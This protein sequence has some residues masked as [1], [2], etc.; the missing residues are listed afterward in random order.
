M[1]L[2]TDQLLELHYGLLGIGS[3]DPERLLGSARRLYTFVILFLD[4]TLF[5]VWLIGQLAFT[6]LL[7]LPLSTSWVNLIIGLLMDFHKMLMSIWKQKSKHLLNVSTTFQAFLG[8]DCA[9]LRMLLAVHDRAA[10]KRLPSAGE[11][12]TLGDAT[13][14]LGISCHHPNINRHAREDR[15]KVQH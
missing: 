14:H 1:C 5:F 15:G 9:A 13:P 7:C 6:S 4:S 10:A 2:G 8:L 3:W 12:F 11:D